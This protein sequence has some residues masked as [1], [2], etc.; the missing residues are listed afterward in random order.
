MASRFRELNAN[1]A[2]PYMMD[3]IKAKENS[4][5]RGTILYDLFYLDCLKYFDDFIEILL[6]GNFECRQ[7]AYYIIEKYA[8]EV[9]D[10]KK[11]MA[12]QTLKANKILVESSFMEDFDEKENKLNFIDQTI[13]LLDV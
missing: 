10:A 11:Q 12:I 7:M 9:V 2:V 3:Y 1:E 6:E 4:E 5:N 13:E 8:T